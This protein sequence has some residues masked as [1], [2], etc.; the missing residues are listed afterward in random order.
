MNEN[1]PLTVAGNRRNRTYT[2]PFVGISGAKREVFRSSVPP[3]GERTSQYAVVLGPFKTRKAAEF[4][5]S[6]GALP[7]A[8]VPDYERAVKNVP[9]PKPLPEL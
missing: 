9:A 3:N 2:R 5:A 8:R 7:Y 1:M 4:A 6:V